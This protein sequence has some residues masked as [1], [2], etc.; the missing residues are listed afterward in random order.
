VNLFTFI[1]TT[2]KNKIYDGHVKRT[3]RSTATNER[4]PPNFLRADSQPVD[5]TIANDRS[6]KNLLAANSPARRLRSRRQFCGIT[7]R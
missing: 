7:V 1:Y 5:G 3:W 6:I 2:M 4:I